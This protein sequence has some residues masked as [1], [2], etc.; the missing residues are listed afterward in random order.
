MINGNILSGFFPLVFGIS[1]VNWYE[2]CLTEE[3]LFQELGL[4]LSDVVYGLEVTC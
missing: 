4:F 2:K 1:L 3:S